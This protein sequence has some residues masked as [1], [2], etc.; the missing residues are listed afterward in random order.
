MVK[1]IFS[2]LFLIIIS[3]IIFSTCKRELHPSNKFPT[4]N[5]G[6][7]TTIVLP[8]DFVKLDGSASSDPDGSIKEW[9]WTKISGPSN[10]TIANA[11]LAATD[12]KNLIAGVYKF[13]LKVT[14]NGGL[15]AKDTVQV[16]VESAPN[17]APIANAGKDTSIVLPVNSVTLNGSASSDPDNN[18][19]SYS[20]AKISGPS[21]YNIA[22]VSS[23]QTQVI[24]LVK[25]TYEFELKVTDAGGL[26]SKDTM[27][28]EVI[29]PLLSLECDNSNR[30]NVNAQII[31]M[32]RLSQPN[33]GMAVASAGNKIL[34]A[35]GHGTSSWGSTRVDIYDMATQ[36]WSTAELS[37][38][39]WGIA[40]VAAG[41]KI[42]FAGGEYGDGAIDT[43]YSTIDIYDVS[44][45]TWSVASL[46]QPRSQIAAAAVGNKV[47]FAGGE[48]DDFYGSNKV[49]IYDLSANTWSTALLSEPRRMMSAVTVANKVYFAGGYN[50]NKDGASSRIDIYN[51]LTNSWSVSSLNEPK[52]D[53][54][55]IAIE[56]KIYWA[57]G[58]KPSN[59]LNSCSVEIKDVNTGNSSIEYLYAPGIWWTDEGNNAVIKDNKIV[60]LRSLS[61]TNTNNKFDIY[62]VTTNTWSIAVL[63]VSLWHPSIISVNN[64]IYVAGGL[65]SDV[66]NSTGQVWKLEF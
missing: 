41:N 12:V 53:F 38:A 2:L 33:F 66:Y 51:D 18:I 27:K 6:K 19:T 34:F 30:P 9:N 15:S 50:E 57:G 3:G 21:S 32:G 14:D 13:E 22:N 58:F 49:D 10:F 55:G 45:N 52:R 65:G 43:H 40:A 42:F 37:E 39:R 7:D 64:T 62:D 28:V 29:Q 11:T 56:N 48:I 24:N 46:S 5:A 61:N 54:A 36:T 26:F 4:A 63:P 17:R 44:S 16:T 59:A 23:V 8:I 47:F 60:F 1:R 25:G 31:P 35:G 20:W